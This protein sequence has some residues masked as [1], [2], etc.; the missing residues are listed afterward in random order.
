ML[1]TVRPY[2]EKLKT[3]ATHLLT[4]NLVTPTTLSVPLTG[5]TPDVWS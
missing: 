5:R 3:R 2:Y 4:S 1:I